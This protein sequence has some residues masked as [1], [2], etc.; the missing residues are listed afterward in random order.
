R[1]S[2]ATGDRAGRPRAP[3]GFLLVARLGAP[4][5]IRESGQYTVDEGARLR[6][7]IMLGELNGLVEDDGARNV[8]AVG[9]LV[10]PEAHHVAVDACHALDSPVGRGAG[11]T[12]IHVGQLLERASYESVC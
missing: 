4:Q 3:S 2:R 5:I 12:S 9:E 6:R 7:A 1:E 8:G 10:S 11:D